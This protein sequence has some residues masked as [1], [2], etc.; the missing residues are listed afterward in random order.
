MQIDF[1]LLKR[2]LSHDSEVVTVIANYAWCYCNK[3]A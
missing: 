2:V 3:S 1:D